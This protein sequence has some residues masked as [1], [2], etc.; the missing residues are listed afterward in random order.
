MA[1]SRDRKQGSTTWKEMSFMEPAFAE[2]GLEQPQVL[3]VVEA[4]A[5]EPVADFTVETRGLK[6]GDS[7]G[8]KQFWTFRYTTREGRAGEATLFVK[9][10][11]WKGRSEAIDY[12]YLAS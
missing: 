8:D 4:V 3:P 1:R 7:G 5:G 6:E 2:F 12:R 11:A 10:C 9:Q